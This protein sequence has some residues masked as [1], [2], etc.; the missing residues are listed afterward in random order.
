MNV[1]VSDSNMLMDE[2]KINLNMLCM[3]VLGEV[4][5][6]VDGADVVAIDKHA[7]GEGYE[8]PEGDRATSSSQTP[9]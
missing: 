2:V 1:D 9:H 5:E 6:E 7:P 4:D 3:L 8:T